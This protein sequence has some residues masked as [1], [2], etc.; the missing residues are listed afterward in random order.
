MAT[1]LEQALNEKSAPWTEIEYRTKDYWV[2]GDADVDTKGCLLFVPT[3]KQF[4]NLVECYKAAYKFGCDGVVSE[5][6][7]SFDI[8]QACGDKT[9]LTYPHISMTPT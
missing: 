4:I 7:K 9:P 3:Q 2:F 6:W 5:R 8:T 1:D